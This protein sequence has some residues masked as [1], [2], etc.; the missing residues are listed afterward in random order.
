MK[1]KLFVM[2]IKQAWEDT[3][4]LSITL[5]TYLQRPV[6]Y[7]SNSLVSIEYFSLVAPMCSIHENVMIVI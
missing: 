6:L 5:Y 1:Q 2:L 4:V 3:D 7:Y